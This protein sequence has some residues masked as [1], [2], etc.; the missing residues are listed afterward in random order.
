MWQQSELHFSV[1][2]SD[3]AHFLIAPE[4]TAPRER[5]LH[6][7]K[8]KKVLSVLLSLVMAVTTMAVF[9]V[10]ASAADIQ[11]L[12]SGEQYSYTFS[13]KGEDVSYKVN[14]SKA[15]TLKIAFSTGISLLDFSVTDSSDHML[16]VSEKDSTLGSVGSNFIYGYQEIKWN[17][18]EQKYK[19]TLSYKVEKGTYYINLRLGG[20]NGGSKVTFKAVFP[21]ATKTTTTSSSSDATITYIVIPMK[22]GDTLSLGTALSAASEEKVTWKSSKSTVAKV[23]SAGKITAKAE[24]TAVITATLGSSSQKIMVKVTK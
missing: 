18:V 12:T 24:G 16:S 6:T 10:S 22:V 4:I 5:K 14:V 15:G 1:R 11:E 7:M 13:K 17:S 9:T 8:A 21:S 3:A 20:T 23:T 2:G 19:G